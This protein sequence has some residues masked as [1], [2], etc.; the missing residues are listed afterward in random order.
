MTKW[1]IKGVAAAS[2]ALLWTSLPVRAQLPTMS[3]VDR[4][5]G[6]PASGPLPEWDVAVVKPHPAEDHNMSWQMTDDGLSLVNLTLEQM[7]CSAWDLKPFQVSGLSG[8]MK[9]TNYDLTAKVVG[10]EVA[11][12]K[13]LNG[14]QRRQMLQT[15]LAERFQLKTHMETKTLP[16]YNLVLSSSGSKLKASTAIDPPSEEEAKANPDKYKKGYMTMG[17]GVFEGSGVPVKSLASQLSNAVGK[18]VHDATGLTGSYDIALHFRPEESAGGSAD[19]SDKPD[20]FSAVQDQLGL[21]LVPG[22]APVE[23]LVVEAAEKPQAD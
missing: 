18:P 19:D 20:I 23:T 5:S 4:N 12:Y 16:V 17:P 7:I 8:R 6:A 3:D 1:F 14:A 9:T 13:K 10:D 22:K 21:K 15:L 11:V 2:V